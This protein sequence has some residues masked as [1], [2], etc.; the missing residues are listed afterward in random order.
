MHWQQTYLSARSEGLR[1]EHFLL[2]LAHPIFLA[3]FAGKRDPLLADM[4][5]D[6]LAEFEFLG[7]V[8]T[9]PQIV[10]LL[11]LCVEVFVTHAD[12]S[13]SATFRPSLTVPTPLRGEITHR[14]PSVP[15]AKSSP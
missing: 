15:S 10:E 11:A 6:V 9:V 14:R 1:V 7:T 8:G 2:Q 3:I 5:A 12:S 13:A 4:L